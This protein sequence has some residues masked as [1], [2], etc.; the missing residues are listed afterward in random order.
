MDW[1]G[2]AVVLLDKNIQY[3]SFLSPFLLLTALQCNYPR[4][5]RKIT[6]SR[7]GDFVL[8]KIKNKTRWGAKVNKLVSKSPA[9]W[10]KLNRR[11]MRERASQQKQSSATWLLSNHKNPH[12]NEQRSP[13]NFKQTFIILRNAPLCAFSTALTFRSHFFSV[14]A[15]LARA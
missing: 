15:S 3:S 9:F 4:K 11:F 2:Y 10:A 14:F 1:D 12:E 7:S 8:P 6:S 5:I 13:Q